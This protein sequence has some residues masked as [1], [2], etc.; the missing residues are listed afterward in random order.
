[1]P[2]NGQE[3]NGKGDLPLTRL[4]GT[5][6]TAA[7]QH[8]KHPHNKGMQFLHVVAQK[9]PGSCFRHFTFF[10]D[11]PVGKLNVSLHIVHQGRIEET[12]HAAQL[13]LGHSSSNGTR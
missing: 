12:Q 4:Y 8:G 5:G 13:T 7:G 9:L 11:Q 3:E 2:T 6:L 1:M 10:R